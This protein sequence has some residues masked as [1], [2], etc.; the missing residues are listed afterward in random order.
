MQY[1][2]TGI[3]SAVYLYPI[4][5]TQSTEASD[6]TQE[7]TAS[8][9]DGGDALQRSE[10]VLL[11]ADSP[12]D[13]ADG[14]DCPGPVCVLIKRR[15]GGAAFHYCPLHAAAPDLLAALECVTAFA[16]DATEEAP[17]VHPSIKAAQAL[18]AKARGDA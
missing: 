16:Y 2:L 10:R 4:N 13:S 5:Q 7:H 12:T 1:P 11:P 14:Q 9:A 8:R 3:L 6:M 17:M 18:I 15:D